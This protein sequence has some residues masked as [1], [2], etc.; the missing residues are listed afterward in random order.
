MSIIFGLSWKHPA[1]ELFLAILVVGGLAIYA[2]GAAPAGVE[3]ASLHRGGLHLFLGMIGLF[4]WARIILHMIVFPEQYLP[5][6]SLTLD[7][8]I[9]EQRE[10]YIQYLGY[11]FGISTLIFAAYKIYLLASVLS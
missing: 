9:Y 10:R 6:R 3:G 2:E 4:V 11:G 5:K 8:Q 1:V 7:A